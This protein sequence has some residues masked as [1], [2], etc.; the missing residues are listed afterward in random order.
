MRR[1]LPANRPVNLP[2]GRGDAPADTVG[3]MDKIEIRKEGD[4]VI[5][6]SPFHPDLPARAGSLGG[7]FNGTDWRFPGA[8]MGRVRDL[9]REIYG[10]DGISDVDLLDIR[11]QLD[12]I[13]TRGK[14]IFVAGRCLAA[15]VKRDAR[16][17]LGHMVTIDKG[18]FPRS[19]GSIENPR[20]MPETGT[21]LIVRELPEPAVKRAMKI[22]PGA[23]AVIQTQGNDDEDGGF[24]TDDVP[25]VA[26][27]V[28]ATKPVQ[29]ATADML[30]PHMVRRENG[31][32]ISFDG[33]LLAE[34]TTNDGSTYAKNALRSTV[35]TLYKTRAGKF[36]A[37]QK[38]L[39]DMTGERTITKA[40]VVDTE[41][42]VIDFFGHRWLAKRLYDM[43]HIQAIEKIG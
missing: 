21:E 30:Q 14:D 34:A 16:V 42:E 35:L 3:H 6:A 40:V 32:D 2:A 20:L 17:W 18:G 10:T 38:N 41:Q 29:A 39:S 31:A 8:L 19:G 33:V 11:I 36:V 5:A 13:D 1:L 43:A 37:V 4:I 23:I 28:A 26:D 22:F 27:A 9:Y 24:G 12:L 25:R 15:R 7:R